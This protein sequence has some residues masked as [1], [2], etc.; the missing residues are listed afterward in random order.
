LPLGCVIDGEKG[1]RG[2][3][4]SRREDSLNKFSFE[5]TGG[6]EIIY[7]DNEPVFMLFTSNGYS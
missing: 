6:V 7:A 5:T 4:L 2:R 3:G 1:K